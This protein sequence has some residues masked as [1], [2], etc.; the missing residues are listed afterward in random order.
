[1]INL[2]AALGPLPSQVTIH[3]VDGHD[4]YGRPQVTEQYPT[5]AVVERTQTT[6]SDNDDHRV[7]DTYRI[8]IPTTQVR[9]DDRITLP[10]GR[11]LTVTDVTISSGALGIEPYAEVVAS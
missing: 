9:V 10:E 3:R 4:T 8:V 2:I 5:P 7:R 6:G 1:M 11:T